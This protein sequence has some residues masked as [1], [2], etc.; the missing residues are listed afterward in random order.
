MLEINFPFILVTTPIKRQSERE[1]ELPSFL[2]SHS[3]H[4]EELINYELSP[5][6]TFQNGV[7]KAYTVFSYFS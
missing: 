5:E 6:T 3:E 7:Y 4:E 1:I 2:L